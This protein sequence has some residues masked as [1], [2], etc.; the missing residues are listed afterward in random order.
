MLAQLLF[1][2]ALCDA[3]AEGDAKSLGV[4]DEDVVAAA[5]RKL[6][7]AVAV[8]GEPRPV[9]AWQSRNPRLTGDP[10]DLLT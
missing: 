6:E 10:W 5:G 8:K 3:V 9:R 1:A 7:G 2:E 4:R